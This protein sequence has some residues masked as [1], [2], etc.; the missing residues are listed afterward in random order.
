MAII[1]QK[2]SAKTVCK[3]SSI[4]TKTWNNS[5]LQFMKVSDL[6]DTDAGFLVRDTVVFVCEIIDCCPWF[7][8]SDLEV[9]LDL[10]FFMWLVPFCFLCWVG[11]NIDDS[12]DTIIVTPNTSKLPSCCIACM[13][14]TKCC[15]STVKSNCSY[16]MC[17]CS[18][19]FDITYNR[20]QKNN[21]LKKPR[22]LIF[23]G[24]LGHIGLVCFWNVWE[25]SDT[26]LRNAN[27]PFL[28]SIAEISK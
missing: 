19:T 3:E 28:Y 16:R 6:L 5:V 14:L 25:Y 21:K 2:N 4:C 10:L 20:D 23:F 15:C 12:H 1:N 22:I 27:T 7:D 11:V 13:L 18:L 8:F 9:R 24:D 17:L 26:S